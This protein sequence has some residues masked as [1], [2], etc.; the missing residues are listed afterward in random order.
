MTSVLTL[1]FKFPCPDT[2]VPRWTSYGEK[3]AYAG[4][5]QGRVYN[6]AL[7]GEA[8]MVSPRLGIIP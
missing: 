1:D 3:G 5:N 2:N 4:S 8:F 6:E 7:Q